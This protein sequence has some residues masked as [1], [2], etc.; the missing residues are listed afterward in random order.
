MES[1]RLHSK[2]QYI[3]YSLGV[4]V[5]TFSCLGFFLTTSQENIIDNSIVC[6]SFAAIFTI[7]YLVN[8]RFL[9]RVRFDTAFI[10]IMP[11][12][13]RQVER[14]TYDQVVSFNTKLFSVFIRGGGSFNIYKL[15]YRL[16]KDTIKTIKLNPTS[17]GNALDKFISLIGN[18]LTDQRANNYPEYLN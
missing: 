7:T 4:L 9:R 17:S 10:Y 8:F 3:P 16:D 2:T 13:G 14:I 1:I 15:T 12:F 5:L 18:N 6:G 11:L